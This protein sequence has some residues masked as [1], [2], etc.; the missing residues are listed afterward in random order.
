MQRLLATGEQSW[1]L[2]Y[3]LHDPRSPGLGSV[4]WLVGLVLRV[5]G[6][7]AVDPRASVSLL[8]GVAP[9]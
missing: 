8:V 7:G 9:F 3:W 1:V 5:D 2:E 6:S 4:L